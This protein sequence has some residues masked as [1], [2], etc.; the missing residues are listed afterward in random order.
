MMIWRFRRLIAAYGAD[1]A[2]W[3]P[4]QRGRVEALLARSDKARAMLAEAKALDALLLAD[5][6]PPAD[7]QL[8][9]AIVARLIDVPQE[10]GPV[11][12][13]ARSIALEWSLSRLWPQAV[14]LAAAAVLGF[15][16]GW[17]DLLPGSFGGGEA[18]D[19]SDLVAGGID[20]GGSLL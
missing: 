1:P 2:R 18:I 15:V 13:P 12:A 7:E 11:I 4:G 19:L 10:R 3:P 14:G 8:A 6:K 16:V 9:A 5:A 20:D 17:A